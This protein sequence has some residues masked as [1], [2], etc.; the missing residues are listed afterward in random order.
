MVVR[1]GEN[2]PPCLIRKRDG[3]TLY[4]TRDLAAAIYRHEHFACERALYVVDAGQSFHFH[5]VFEVL[6]RM[7][8]PCADGCFHVSFGLVLG[9]GE[10]GNWSKV[11]TR[12]GTGAP[13]PDVMDRAAGRIRETM[14]ALA[15]KRA[16]QDG[17]ETDSFAAAE[18]DRLAEAVG[19]GALVFNELKNRRMADTKFDLDAILSFEGDTGPY[20]MYA[21]VRLAGILR[22][23]A[24]K[25]SLEGVRWEL[26]CEPETERVASVIA[27]FPERIE[28]A[29]EAN[30]PSVI[31]QYAL[32]LAESVHSFTHHHRVLDVDATRERLVLV[33]AA[34]RTLAK[35][36]TLLGLEPV[37]RM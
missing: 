12:S 20:I 23:A 36:L 15:K 27:Q 18:L 29:V 35:A 30:E 3:A 26:L 21:H 34:R 19:V 8:E 25:P 4:A 10:D 11:S 7:G 22:K 31:A 14:A 2:I 37:E 24:M 1:V 9:K 6:R 13:L 16:E 5:Q 28:S 17:R 32:E 33:E